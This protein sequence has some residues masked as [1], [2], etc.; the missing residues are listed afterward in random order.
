LKLVLKLSLLLVPALVLGLPAWLLLS[1]I[2]TE[3]LVPQQDSLRQDDLGRIKELLQQHDPRN[4][5]DGET[6]RLEISG[7][8][9]NLLL[10]WAVPYAERQALRV[11]LG[12]GRMDLDYS[13]ALPDNPLGQFLNLSARL[14]QNGS[15]LALERLRFGNTGLPGWL[16][17]PVIA[18]A[19][20][21]LSRRSAEYRDT[22]AAVRE[23]TLQPGALQIV[24]QWQSG[25]ARRLHS[26]GR[27]LL[28][29]ALDRERIVAYYS[30]ISRQSLT[31]RGSAVSLDRLLQPLFALAQRR[32]GAGND[33]AAE[34]RALLLALGVTISGKSIEYLVGSEAIAGLPRPRPV[35]LTLGG[36]NDLAK[37]FSVSA[38]ITAAGGSALA[39]NIGVFKEVDDSRGGSGFSFADLL[40]DR[41]GVSLAEV[42]LG[43]KARELQQ[44]LGNGAQEADYMPGFDALPEGLM[45]LEFRARYED[46]DSAAYALVDREIERRLASCAIHRQDFK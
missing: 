38:A 41:A 30:E 27:E 40:A 37:H 34:N 7:S 2:Q 5:R 31:Q 23:V 46:L 24:Y 14:G 1:A 28:L 6:R 12:Q 17:T 35:N 43:P 8:D 9:I 25:L 39:D 11:G 45:E 10:R 29:P 44:H 13:L 36:R 3:P 4:L 18:F 42:A 20:H 26:T 15:H 16:L 22:L 33:P 32:S 21:Y 19:D